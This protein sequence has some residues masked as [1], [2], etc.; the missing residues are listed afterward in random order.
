MGISARRGR[1]RKDDEGAG[2][3]YVPQELGQG[4]RQCVVPHLRQGAEVRQEKDVKA[5]VEE[6]KNVS[7]LAPQA[8]RCRF[9]KD[10]RIEPGTPLPG[11]AQPH[12][13]VD[14]ADELCDHHGGQGARAAQAERPDEKRDAEKIHER[15]QGRHAVV[16]HKLLASEHD[17]AQIIAAERKRDQ[18][19]AG[20]QQNA[21]DSRGERGNI[22]ENHE[23]AVKGR[24]QQGQQQP[25]CH[26]IGHDVRRRE[27]SGADEVRG[28]GSEA[29][30]DEQPGQAGDEDRQVYGPLAVRAEKPGE[31]DARGERQQDVEGL[32]SET[33]E[34]PQ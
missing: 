32:P 28:G 12:Q 16:D 34:E 27:P 31:E 20:E 29:E 9:A 19:T 21:I 6:L 15:L 7:G 18:Q 2:V 11:T 1:A 13:K 14:H 3:R 8:I 22:P 25:G 26:E 30:I 33:A 5:V 17:R 23:G 24:Q 4:D 10:R